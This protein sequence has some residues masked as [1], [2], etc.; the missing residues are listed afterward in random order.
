MTRDPN[1][2]VY[3]HKTDKDRSEQANGLP[4]MAKASSNAT[5]GTVMKNPFV[6]F[7]WS[8]GLLCL[9]FHIRDNFTPDIFHFLTCV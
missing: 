2:E 6:D 7:F 4:G 1:L 8:I 3:E 5:L 9:L